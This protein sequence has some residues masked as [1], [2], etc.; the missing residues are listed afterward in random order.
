MNPISVLVIA[1]RVDVQTM[2]RFWL[3]SRGHRVSCVSGENQAAVL[4]EIQ[5]F[6]LVI[7]EIL[8][9]TGST[10]QLVGQLKQVC[11]SV[12]ILAIFDGLRGTSMKCLQ[13]AQNVGAHALL[14]KPFKEEQLFEAIERVFAANRGHARD[15]DRNA[16]LSVRE[17]SWSPHGKSLNA[18]VLS[19]S[20]FSRES[21]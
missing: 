7:A 4:C 20:I 1:G 12:R 13:I 9:P 17:G 10:A 6:D 3:Q 5:R 18:H 11:E 21:P 8:R 19:E 16:P 15:V 14:L 2:L